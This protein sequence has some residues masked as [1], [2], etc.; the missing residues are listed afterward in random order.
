MSN[1]FNV[2]G[3][4]LKAILKYLSDTVFTLYFT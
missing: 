4:I 3:T 1:T 2:V